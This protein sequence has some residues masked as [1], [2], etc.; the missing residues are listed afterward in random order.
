MGGDCGCLKHTKCLLTTE[1]KELEREDMKHHA[2]RLLLNGALHITSF[3]CE[4][5][6]VLDLG[7]GTG[8][9]HELPFRNK[10]LIQD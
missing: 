1:Q 5:L 2:T 8:L 4:P 9:C 6:N 7:T 3:E 10:N